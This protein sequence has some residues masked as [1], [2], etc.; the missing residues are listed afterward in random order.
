MGDRDFSEVFFSKRAKD[1]RSQS[2]NY[3]VTRLIEFMWN[4]ER[5]IG[6][7]TFVM[8]AHHMWQKGEN[9]HNNQQ[10]TEANVPSSHTP[11]LPSR[12]CLLASEPTSLESFALT[13]MPCHS[14][15]PQIKRLSYNSPGEKW[16]SCLFLCPPH[17]LKWQEGIL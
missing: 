15:N 10:H 16:K 17:R 13:Q 8:F 4:A 2:T 14:T 12:T 11:L 7:A 1:M 6:G 9:G 3:K 5:M